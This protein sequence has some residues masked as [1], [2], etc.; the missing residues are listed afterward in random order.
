[1]GLCARLQG[2][3]VRCLDYPVT[4][5]QALDVDLAGP[6]GPRPLIGARALRSTEWAVCAVLGDGTVACMEQLT[7]T[8]NPVMAVI[9]G[10]R[11]IVELAAGRDHFCARTRGGEVSCWGGN[12]TGQLGDG[13]TVYSERP[14]KVPGMTG[15]R[16]LAAGTRHTCALARE[17]EVYCWGD[18][19]GN[20]RL[21][22]AAANA[23]SA[24]PVYVGHTESVTSEH[25]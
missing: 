25:R 1:M 13:T 15:V 18:H 17:R 12:N 24:S 22:H 8:M 11:D 20:G 19:N 21:A 16:E 23:R 4:D 14:V 9:P 5:N 10:L 6:R 7:D 3:S 2:G